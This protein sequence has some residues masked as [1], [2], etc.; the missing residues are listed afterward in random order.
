MDLATNHYWKTL[1]G[2]IVC[3]LVPL[4][5]QAE[6]DV[7]LPSSYSLPNGVNGNEHNFDN[8]TLNSLTTHE[9]LKAKLLQIEQSAINMIKV[10][11]LIENGNNGGLI[12]IDVTLNMGLMINS[13]VCGADI[14]TVRQAVIC[15]V[16]DGGRGN[17]DP[18]KI[19]LS[20][21]GRELWG[22]RLGNENGNKVMFITQ[23][24]GN[25]VQSTEAALKVIKNLANSENPQTLNILEKLDILF[26][27]RAN[28]DG[29]EPSSD[30]FIGTPL[31]AVIQED[32]A[33]TRTNVDPQAGGAYSEVSEND[34]FGTVGVGYNVTVH[35]LETYLYPCN[36]AIQY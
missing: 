9:Q 11:P 2:L 6:L 3:I 35:G 22:A 21:Q 17:Q 25:E 31:G 8:Q 27:V 32:C 29:G 20:T 1:A 5:G 33:M 19:G 14:P 23:Q 36:R 13:D 34:F 15:T 28:P 4:P 26:I 18:D 30:C 10:G 12:N 24:H 16:N 7:T